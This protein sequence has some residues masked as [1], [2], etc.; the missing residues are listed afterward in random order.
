MS[1]SP[2]SGATGASVTANYLA[3]TSTNSRSGT[4]TISGNIVAVSQVGAPPITG[5]SLSLSDVTGTPG[6][7]VELPVTLA[8]A[9]FSIAGFQMDVA[10]DPQLL[11]FSSARKGDALSNAGKD[12]SAQ[13]LN[14][15]SVR[16]SAFGLNQ[17]AI[18]DGTVAYLTFALSSSA[19]STT[20][21]VL[22]CSNAEGVT[23][24]SQSVVLSCHL[25]SITASP[26]NAC[27]IN[28][29]GGVNVGDVQVE[30]NAALSPSPSSIYDLNRDGRVDVGDVQIVINAALGMGCSQGTH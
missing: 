23:P 21:T 26:K 22:S 3:N 1:I 4:V 24:Q 19:S 5:A 12:V 25:G 13:S 10:F 14:S 6:A 30:I 29:D 7:T 8:T 18:S 11:S 27:D 2:A 16:L 20:R 17:G 9:G 28:Q 15:G